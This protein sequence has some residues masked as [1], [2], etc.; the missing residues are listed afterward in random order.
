MT[1]AASGLMAL[2]GPTA[3]R[4]VNLELGKAAGA[5][6]TMNDAAPRVLAEKN[7]LQSQISMA[8]FYGK[9]KDTSQV[10]LS[11]A[12]DGG[13]GVPN[14]TTSGLVGAGG[15]W[16]I[17]NSGRTI[18]FTVENSANCGG[19][20]PNQQSGYARAVI[21]GGSSGYRFVPSMVGFGERHDTGF[22]QMT[23]YFNG[24]F[25][26]QGDAPGGK[27]GCVTAGPVVQTPS[28]IP[29]QT[30]APGSTNTFECYFDTV[31]SLYHVN[32]Y[33]ILQLAFYLL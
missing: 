11:V 2:G 23:L 3:T 9:S 14:P 29:F 7:T 28:S 5:V 15:G 30:I 19:P 8:D 22:D 27:Q 32:S 4:S 12:W 18:Q 16:S 33:Y 31:D 17:T 25:V 20:N 24:S 1:L 10:L 26:V 13:S 6:I 21:T